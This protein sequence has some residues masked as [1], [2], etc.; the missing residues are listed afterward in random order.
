MSSTYMSSADTRATEMRAAAWAPTAEM[1]TAEVA[2]ATAEMRAATTTEMG[3]T[4]TTA[5]V[6]STTTKVSPAAAANVTATTAAKMATASTAAASLRRRCSRTGQNDR[7]N[8]SQDIE[9][10]HAGFRH[11]ALEA[12]G[13]MKGADVNA[14]AG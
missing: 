14:R 4:A 11:G 8:N 3:T 1:C 2:S 12:R 10:R 13:P 6:R 7:Q 5:K 9:F